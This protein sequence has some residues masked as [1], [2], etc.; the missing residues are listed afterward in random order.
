M[1]RKIHIDSVREEDREKI[2]EDLQIK[3]EGSSYVSNSAPSYIYPLQVTDEHAYIPFSYGRTCAGSPFLC[4][5]RDTFGKL[6]CKFEGSL[7]EHQKSIK[8][9]AISHLNKYGSTII[10]A[11]P[12]I[13]KC[14]RSCYP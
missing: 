10:A 7:R 13:G 5:E 8:T 1:S 2:L 12:G 11:Y 3:I 6:T 14:L 4:P 9:E